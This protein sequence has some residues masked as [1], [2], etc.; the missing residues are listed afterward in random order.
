[1]LNVIILAVV[2]GITEFLPVSSSGHL[3]ILQELLGVNAPGAGLEIALHLGTLLSI[4]FFYRRDLAELIKSLFKTHSDN[5]KLSWKTVCFVFIGSIPAGIIGIL[6]DEKIEKIFDNPKLASGMLLITAVILLSTLLS[7]RE[8]KKLGFANSLAIGIS[9]A[10]AIL[11]GISRS[12]ST[13]ACARIF[14]IGASDAARFS[15]Y[16]AIVSISGAALLKLI[17]SPGDFSF[18]YICGAIIA[19]IVGY[20]ALKILIGLLKKG[21]LWVFAPYCALVG[22]VG[23]IFL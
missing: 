22:I 15:F 21:K 9:Q 6:F 4:I 19:A 10:I 7:K 5:F 13:I 20:F 3:V 17:K 23:L 8:N 16:L 1:M 12:G 2:Q 11:P 14:G 18:A